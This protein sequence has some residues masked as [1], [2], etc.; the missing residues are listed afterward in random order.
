[1]ACYLPNNLLHYNT[2]ECT[3]RCVQLDTELVVRHEDKWSNIFTG[4]LRYV[5]EQVTE[6]TEQQTSAV[7]HFA[8][9]RQ[10]SDPACIILLHGA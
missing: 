3:V 4:M 10:A 8:Q 1:V 2:A 7:K 9:E 6:T 5:K